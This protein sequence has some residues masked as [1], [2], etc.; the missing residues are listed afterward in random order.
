[1]ADLMLTGDAG[2]I[3]PDT[4]PLRE[5]IVEITQKHKGMTTVVDREGRLLGVITDGDLRRLHLSGGP[6]ETLPPAPVPNHAP[7]VRGPKD[8]TRPQ[9]EEGN[10]KQIRHELTD[11]QD[12]RP[13]G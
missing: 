9:R 12:D 6:I 8:R 5:V 1:M 11:E 10:R 3:V 4:T 7:K 13:V 2:P